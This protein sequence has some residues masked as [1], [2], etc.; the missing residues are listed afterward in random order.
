MP[1]ILRKIRKPKW[2]DVPWLSPGDTIADALGDLKTEDNKLSVWVIEDDESNLPLVA[3]ALVAHVFEHVQHFDYALLELSAIEQQG[4]RME[5]NTGKTPC[6]AANKYHRDIVQLSAQDVMQI[7]RIVK[8]HARRE[9]I[10]EWQV[11][12]LLDEAVRESSLDTLRMKPGLLP[13]LEKNRS[14]WAGR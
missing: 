12:K 14:K 13:S 2:Y 1:I 5:A 9:R 10:P 7:A 11:G 6:D 3:T 4:W 8:N